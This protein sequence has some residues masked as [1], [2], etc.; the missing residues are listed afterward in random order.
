MHAVQNNASTAGIISMTSV[1]VWSNMPYAF[2]TAV[3]DAN[4]VQSSTVDMIDAFGLAASQR[5]AST[6]SGQRSDLMHI[7][8]MPEVR[9]MDECSAQRNFRNGG[10]V[11][12]A[13]TLL[14]SSAEVQ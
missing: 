10:I 4:Q 12:T 9:I 1:S 14:V 11:L 6:L 13:I 8:L 2:A 5:F 7:T 3:D